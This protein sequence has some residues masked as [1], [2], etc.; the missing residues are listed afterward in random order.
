MPDMLNTPTDDF[1]LA[2]TSLGEWRQ[3]REEMFDLAAERLRPASAQTS[4]PPLM[5]I[6]PFP[7]LDARHRGAEPAALVRHAESA[8]DSD[9]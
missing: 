8:G 4:V 3:M 7:G 2:I 5:P 9:V 6:V 1:G